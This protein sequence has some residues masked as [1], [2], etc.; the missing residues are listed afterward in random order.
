MCIFDVFTI[1]THA[2]GPM[3]DCGPIELNFAS[4]GVTTVTDIYP[5]ISG[6]GYGFA[7]AITRNKVFAIFCGL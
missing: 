7:R 6:V 4:Y 3:Q 2:R 1:M 5:Q